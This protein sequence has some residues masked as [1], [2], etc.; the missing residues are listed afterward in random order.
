[1]KKLIDSEKKYSSSS[2]MNTR[3]WGP[4]L[5]NSLFIMILGSYPVKIEQYNKEHLKIKKSFKNTLTGLQY[6]LPCIFCRKSFAEF[7]KTLDINEF[8]SG[9]I[10]LA[11]W[12]YTIKDL[13]NSKL[14]KQ[15]TEAKKEGRW[16]PE[17]VKSPKFKDVLDKYEKYRAKCDKKLKRCITKNTK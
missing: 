7:L 16:C 17:T 13:V 4:Q 6:T 2:G 11:F 10:K 12:L 9:R 3:T 8:L 5:W 1:M 14:I 15:S